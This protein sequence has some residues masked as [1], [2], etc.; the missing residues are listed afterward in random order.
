MPIARGH[1]AEVI[2]NPVTERIEMLHSHR[3]GG[4]QNSTGTTIPDRAED[5]VSTLNL[6]SIDPDALLRGDARWQ[7]DGTLLKRRGFSRRG[8]KDGLH[9]GGS[10]VDRNRNMQHI[11]IYAGWRRAPASI[12]RISRTLD[13]PKLLDRA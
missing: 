3:W 12:F 2:Y 13:T 8:N 10:I 5:E 6:W 7:F 1:T 9:P 4:G 11:F